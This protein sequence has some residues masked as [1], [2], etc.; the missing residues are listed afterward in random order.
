MS[1]DSS[2]LFDTGYEDGSHDQD[3]TENPGDKEDM[4]N[5]PA[6]TAVQDDGQQAD[7]VTSTRAPKPKAK[8]R[9]PG[10]P[11]GNSRSPSKP[12]AGRLAK[13]GKAKSGAVGAKPTPTAAKPSKAEA[14]AVAKARKLATRR[15]AALLKQ[16]ADGTRIFVLLA[17]A[18]EERNVG[19]I[20][21]LLDQSQPATSHHLALMRHG[22][23]I[24]PRRD[25]KNNIYSLTD[26]GRMLAEV[27]RPLVD[28]AVR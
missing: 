19:A 8:G 3:P 24:E 22:R 2:N 15:A 14:N 26:E 18:D 17:L 13:P 10:Q 9:K 1:T 6:S 21:K 4:G 16:V 7:A 12:P 5:S 11:V 20:C 25:G 23:L 28:D 27:I